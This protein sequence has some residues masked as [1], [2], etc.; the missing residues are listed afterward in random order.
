MKKHQR[1]RINCTIFYSLLYSLLLAGQSVSSQNI[2]KWYVNMPDALNPTL[3]KQNR[4]ELLEYHKA[5]KGDSITNRFGNQAYLQRMDTTNQ[6]LV[7]KN[8]A[9]STFEMKGFSLED[10]MPVIGLIRTVCG[11]ICQS[12]VGFYDTAWNAIP[13]QFTMPKAF[14]WVNK[15]KYTA[16]SIDQ[17]W[18][19]N[20]LENSFITLAFNPD[21]GELIAKNNSLEFLSVADR[22]LITPLVDDKQILFHLK[23]RTWIQEP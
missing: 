4:L 17:Q 18:V 6:Y 10:G 13:L 9:S 11:P 7:V 8:T 19:V 1:T 20:V 22:K 12:T 2:E 21:K 3:S 23:G 16:V 14:E 15:E 5:G